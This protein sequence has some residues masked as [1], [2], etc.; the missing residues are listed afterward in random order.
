MA[1]IHPLFSAVQR[2]K[3]EAEGWCSLGQV[4]SPRRLQAMRERLDGII[5]MPCWRAAPGLR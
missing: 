4:V 3:F 1:A 5:R 2:A